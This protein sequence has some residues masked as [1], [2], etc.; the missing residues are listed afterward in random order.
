PEIGDPLKG[1]DLHEGFFLDLQDLCRS[2]LTPNG[3]CISK[4]GY[5]KAF[6]RPF[7]GNYQGPPLT[8][9]F[10]DGRFITYWFMY[11][12]NEPGTIPTVDGVP[13]PGG[14][15]A[16]RHEGE[17]E[18]VTV[19]LDVTNHALGVWYFTHF[20]SPTFYPANIVPKREGHPLVYS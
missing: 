7:V 18:R 8:Y 16:D 4:F 19:E 20:C 5:L 14:M 2:G 9:N 10:L 3:A 15:A 11:G 12:F 17:W 1:A 6:V 13:F